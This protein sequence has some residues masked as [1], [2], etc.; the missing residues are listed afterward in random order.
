MVYN[1]IAGGGAVWEAREPLE[2]QPYKSGLCKA[3]ATSSHF[4]IPVH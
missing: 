1:L 3:L 4:L 2:G